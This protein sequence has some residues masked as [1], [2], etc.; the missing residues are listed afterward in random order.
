MDDHHV[1]DN[2]APTM[3][4]LV[5]IA[6]AVALIGGTFVGGVYAGAAR[7]TL[8][9]CASDDGTGPVPCVWDA[10]KQ[11]N[12]YGRSFVMTDDGV[13][14]YYGDLTCTPDTTANEDHSACIAL[15]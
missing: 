5:R 2:Y 7:D 15:P 3:R 1:T 12:G 9:A 13:A 6:A 4:T 14:H 10:H 8:P 11:G